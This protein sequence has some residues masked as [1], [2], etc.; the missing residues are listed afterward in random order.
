[1][2]RCGPKLTGDKADISYKGLG[3]RPGGSHVGDPKWTNNF[4][5]TLPLTANKPDQLIVVNCRLQGLPISPISKPKGVKVR[6]AVGTSAVALQGPKAGCG[7]W[8]RL[9][10]TR[11]P[12]MTFMDRAVLTRAG[13]RRDVTRESSTNHVGRLVPRVSGSVTPKYWLHF[14]IAHMRSAGGRSPRPCS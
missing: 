7:D 12:K 11:Q 2:R 14:R 3:D 8:A 13:D 10:C 6:G 4:G 9:S 5:V 1:M